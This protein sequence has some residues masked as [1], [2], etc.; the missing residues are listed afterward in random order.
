MKKFFSYLIP[1][2]KEYWRKA[3]DFKGRT[4]RIEFWATITASFIATAVVLIIGKF[5][6]NPT[7]VDS[8]ITVFINTAWFLI[9]LMP[10]VAVE[11]RRL[12][13]A[14]GSIWWSPAILIARLVARTLDRPSRT[15]LVIAY[16]AVG[17]VPL[18][19]NCQPS[20]D[21]KQKIQASN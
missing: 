7:E 21:T 16:L 6:N 1:S 11:I 4:T 15:Y 14:G 10:M 18:W 8:D 19:Y 9:N 13:D 17:L 20:Y 3:A 2:Y 5:I 12:R